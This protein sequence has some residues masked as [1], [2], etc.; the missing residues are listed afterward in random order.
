MKNKD[1]LLEELDFATRS[2]DL[3]LAQAISK[4]IDSVG[5]QE[6]KRAGPVENFLADI[7]SAGANALT[8]PAAMFAGLTDLA[9]IGA[10]KLGAPKQRKFSPLVSDL[11]NWAAGRDDSNR[12][13]PGF[14]QGLTGGV[15]SRAPVRDVGFWRT[16]KDMGTNVA[17]GAGLGASQGET[18]R[19]QLQGGSIGGLTA[20]GADALLR[21]ITT[22]K[23]L[24]PERQRMV[25]EAA[26]EKI[27]LTG[28]QMTG[29]RTDLQTEGNFSQIRM[30]SQGVQRRIDKQENAFMRALSKRLGI[31][32]PNL[33]EETLRSARNVAVTNIREPVKGGLELDAQDVGPLFDLQRKIVNAPRAVEK[34]AA[35]DAVRDAFDLIGTPVNADKFIEIRSNLN[36]ARTKAF[37]NG[38]KFS[39]DIID[40]VTRFI[41]NAALRAVVP[42]Q[43]EQFRTGLRQYA[44]LMTAED[45][46]RRSGPKGGWLGNIDPAK[47]APAV[48]RNMPGGMLYN[49][50]DMAPVGRVGSVMKA[51]EALPESRRYFPG[52]SEV[53][54]T[55]AYSRLNNPVNKWA[56]QNPEERKQME[57]LFRALGIATGTELAD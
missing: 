14:V 20:L 37:D 27:P 19:E 12:L 17:V 33:N 56:M 44:N 16:V 49:R 13:G 50:S 41:E 18:E 55:I 5:S 34:K 2:G 42:A 31:D 21:G 1:Q 57:R 15:F 29:N 48:E 54:N 43:R 35:M 3:E 53:E 7:R 26:K 22:G 32:V 11:R 46:L 28:A 52:L 40:E 51:G 38:D 24:Q 23:Q 10:E 47:V 36:E 9:S 4:E 39:A 6:P 45:A 25:A 8:G 30:F